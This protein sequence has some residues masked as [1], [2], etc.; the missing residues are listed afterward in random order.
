MARPSLL[1]LC[2]TL[3][4]AAALA[5]QPAV[6]K[7]VPPYTLPTDGAKA[8]A[9][10]CASCHGPR[11]LGDGPVAASLKLPTPNLT[12]LAQ[13]NQG[14]FPS[15]RVAESIKGE[16]GTQAHGSADMPVWGPAFRNMDS[17]SEGATQVRVHNLVRYLESLQAK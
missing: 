5:Q 2:A 3:A 16:T 11:G 8:Y 12:T 9:A 1:L 13:R 7:V 6:K 14:Q 10:Y 17:R 4:C 15:S